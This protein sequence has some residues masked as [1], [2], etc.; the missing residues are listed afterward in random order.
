MK[1]SPGISLGTYRPTY[2]CCY[3]SWTNGEE[4]IRNKNVRNNSLYVL[5]Q[6]HWRHILITLCQCQTI[7]YFGYPLLPEV[8]GIHLLTLPEKNL[9][10]NP[11]DNVWGKL[12]QLFRAK[13][14]S[15]PIIRELSVEL[16]KSRTT[17]HKI[18]RFINA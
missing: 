5:L 2:I 11:I 14:H 3:K 18:D 4:N 9:D 17:Y 15:P 16:Q 1:T 12:V 6:F 10:R 7:H 13:T 8:V